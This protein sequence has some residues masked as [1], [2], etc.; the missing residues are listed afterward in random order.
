MEHLVPWLQEN[1]MGLENDEQ[2]TQ[3]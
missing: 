3:D 1:V 2:L